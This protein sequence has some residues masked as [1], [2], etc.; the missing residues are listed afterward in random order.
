[1]AWYKIPLLFLAT[2]L[3]Q[4]HLYRRQSLCSTPYRIR[5]HPRLTNAPVVLSSTAK[6]GEMEV[7]ISVGMDKAVNK[8]IM[9]LRTSSKMVTANANMVVVSST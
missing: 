7:R 1:M 9:D 6:D 4:F 2:G 8:E 5:R 3:S